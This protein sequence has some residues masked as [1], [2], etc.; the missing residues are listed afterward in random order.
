MEGG[1]EW[2]GGIT[3]YPCASERYQQKR[4]GRLEV[5]LNGS[6]GQISLRGLFK[7]RMVVRETTG[8]DN[9]RQW[10]QL[11]SHL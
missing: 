6:Q 7:D 1:K 2:K 3:L 11:D 4:T 5:M 9:N 8:R 10:I